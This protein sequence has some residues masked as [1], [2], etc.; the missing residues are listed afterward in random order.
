MPSERPAIR[1]GDIIGAIDEIGEYVTGLGSAAALAEDRKSLRAV[2][3]CLQIVS[4]AASKL[5]PQAE[6]LCPGVPWR[7]IRAFGNVLRHGYDGLD[8]TTIRNDLPPLRA[9]CAAALERL[10][11]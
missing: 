9:T 11:G 1:L 10:G 6:A 4:E 3:R 7:E 8:E 2:E 5:G